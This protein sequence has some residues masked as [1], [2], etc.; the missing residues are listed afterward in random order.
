ME[1]KYKEKGLTHKEAQVRFVKYGPNELKEKIFASPWKIFLRQIKNNFIIYLLLVAMTLSFFVGKSV[2]AYTILA[3]II[4]VITAGFIQE[5]RAEKVIASL[6]S[7]IVPISI[8]IRD[9]KEQEIE[10]N[11]LVPGDILILRNGEKI[12]ADCIILE[13][14][15]ILV[16]EAI[17]TGESKEVSK[18]A[19]KNEASYSDSNML[20]MG[21]FIVNGRAIAK[22]IHTGMNTKFGQIAGMIATAEKKLPLQEK[23]NLIAKY[24]VIVAITFAFLTGLLMF[25]GQPYSKELLIESLIL[26]IALAVSAFPEGLPVVL[27][28]ALAHGSYV[29]AKKNAIVNRMSIIETLGEATVIC[30]DKTGTLTKGEMTAVGIYSDNK[31]FEISG[32]GYE[33]KGDFTLNKNIIN[34]EKENVLNY[35]LR[36]SIIC[37]DARIERTGEDEIYHVFG[38]PTESALMIAAAKAKIFVEDI[39]GN[40]FE[41]IPFSSERKM[42]TI[43]FKS[44]NSNEVFSKGAP[45]ILLSKCKFIKRYN[46][47][48]KL[49]AK[50]K[51]T[52]LK[53]NKQMT[54]QMLRT[55]AL[56]YKT[57][58]SFDKDHFEEDL[59]FLGLV[60][61]Q[62]P[63]REEAKEAIRDCISAGI[64]VKMITG[65]NKETA[66][67]IA[68]QIGIRGKVLE[69]AD[70]D[71]MTLEE[72]AAVVNGVAVFARVKPEH[73][74]MIVK[75]L[76][77]NGEVV[78]MTG[79]GVNDSPALKEAHIGIAMGKNGTDVSRSVADLTLKDDNF[80][81][82]VTAI[83]EGRTIFKNI[84]K[85]VSYQ[86]SCNYAELTILFIGV[87]LAPFFGWQIPLLLAL[88]I[89]FMNLVTDDLPAITLALTP[90]SKDIMNE[91]PRKNQKI[92]TKP[93]FI[94][95]LI[96]GI[97]MA[98]F[99]LLSYYIAFNKL[100]QTTIDAR[101]TTLLI[102]ILLE[103]GGAYNFLSF[104]KEVYPSSFLANKYLFIAS[105]ISII[106]TII[107]IYTP[108]NS[109]F[110]TTPIGYADWIFSIIVALLLIIIFN[111]LKR[112]N[113]T[114]KFLELD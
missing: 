111:I 60:G 54:S 17:L 21:S 113:N 106:A 87:I 83:R 3:V 68:N 23:V 63:P 25:L 24:M 74:L 61:I 95:L 31:Y 108:L 92:L 64:S 103:I 98:G 38:N 78:A 46:G 19:V 57:V 10:T 35:L 36:A 12:P 77:S 100:G 59:I 91:K 79:D 80:A 1:S 44:K 90:S 41:E 85:F 107:I 39:S 84:R 6:K 48:F 69:G 72:L 29:M 75:A 86:L 28:T 15:E 62:D 102:L 34:P 88:Q 56:A 30:T 16:N 14:K 32:T 33:A 93:F 5:Y 52:I 112:I 65:D 37:N 43:L 89:L 99:T 101:T 7:M 71:K 50:E 104:R 110:G 51:E 81:T 82:I 96:A 114:K 53:K 27:T 22:V 2:T 4:L 13:E 70:I 40:R 11:R 42:M 8:V 66:L 105:I 26:M 58:K 55:I 9:G 49:T 67:A 47:V 18:N 109:V 73:K 20:F 45:E 97:L 94:W 76:K